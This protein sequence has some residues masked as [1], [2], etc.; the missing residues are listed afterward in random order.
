MSPAALAAARVADPYHG[1]VPPSHKRQQPRHLDADRLRL[2]TPRRLALVAVTVA[3]VL[4][5]GTAAAGVLTGG[6]VTSAFASFAAFDRDD[7][8]VAAREPEPPATD[9]DAAPLA[10]RPSPAAAPARFRVIEATRLKRAPKEKQEKPPNR[11][12]LA[13][14]VEKE[15]AQPTIPEFGVAMINI[16]GSQH[17]AGGKGGFASG[18]SRARTA[19]GMLLGRGVSVIGFSEIQSD[20]LNVFLSNAP[21]FEVYPGHALGGA[22]VPQSVAWDTRVWRMVEATSITIPFNGQVRPQ[23]IVR[24]EHVTTGAQ[25]W[26]MNVHNAPEGQEGE[27]DRAESTEIAK[28]NELKATG[29]PIVVTGDFNEKQEVL[30][31]VT[32]STGLI[33]AVGGGNCYPPPQQMRVDWIFA[34]ASLTVESYDVTRDP[35]VPSITDHAVLFS[36]LS[37]S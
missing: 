15:A 32:G 21:T 28:I 31:R 4:V 8:A 2:R 10:A 25:M 33:S 26:V 19:T 16:L 36:R 30:C 5:G 22:G 20:Q 18:V 3:L 24:L 23:P 17:T 37:L 12:G 35:P 7:G 14:K 1:S 34:S 9:D 11:R 13:D 27:R 6:S 29:L